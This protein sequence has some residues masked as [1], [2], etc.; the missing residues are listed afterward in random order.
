MEKGGSRTARYPQ[1]AHKAAV[2]VAGQLPAPIGEPG[3]DFLPAVLDPEAFRSL[4]KAGHGKGCRERRF[5]KVQVSQKEV[6]MYHVLLVDDGVDLLVTADGH[7]ASPP[8]ILTVP[9]IAKTPS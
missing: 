5:L 9:I 4:R 8:Q 7:T 6:V 1:D 3:G 2:P